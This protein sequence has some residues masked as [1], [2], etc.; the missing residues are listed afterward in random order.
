MSEL[1]DTLEEISSVNTFEPQKIRQ[2]LKISIT[3]PE[4]SMAYI[5]MEASK[6][7]IVIAIVSS[8]RLKVEEDKFKEHAL[9]LKMYW[10][11][12]II[13]AFDEGSQT[14]TATDKVRIY[15]WFYDNLV[16]GLL[17]PPENI[18]FLS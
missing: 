13:M 11:A 12:V 7:E 6:F 18:I 3:K 5:I 15:K 8:T 2:F 10:T 14:A 17:F 16:N 9:V 1:S 4:V